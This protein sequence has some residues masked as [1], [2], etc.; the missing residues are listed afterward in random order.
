MSTSLL[1]RVLGLPGYQH[2]SMKD[3]GGIIRFRVRPPESALCCPGCKS[4]SITRRGTYTRLVHAPPIGSR[5]VLFFIDA[6]RVACERCKTV[7]IIKLPGVV[8]KTNHT[9]SLIRMV[10]DLRKMMTI[11]DIAG[12]LGVSTTMIR[13]IDKQY[14]KTHF[15]K[16]RL[17][18]VRQ[19][20]IDEISVRKGH[21]Y[22][23]IVMDLETGAIIFAAEGKGEKSLQSFWKRLRGSGAKVE[24]AATDMS[25]AYYAAVQKNLPN[26]VLVFDR[27]HIAK[28][29]N[30]KLTQLRRELQREAEGLGKDVLKGT[31]WLLLKAPDKLKET[32]NER[33]RLEDALS[34]NQS[35]ATA[36][37]LKEDLRQV[38]EQPGR[39]AASRFLTDWCR[40][41][42]ASGIRVLLTMANT[43]EGYRTGILDWY[44]YPISTGPLEGTNNKIKTM[45]RQAYGYR[46]IEYFKLKLYALHQAK[47]KL[48]G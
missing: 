23:T 15:G 27:F 45:K 40:R 25:S 28:L 11:Q 47:F 12:W 39:V 21:R 30:D 20:A 37:Y 2:Q 33:Q 35:L 19:I 10:V 3:E 41:A 34:L 9:H 5:P 29:M 44:F 14:L 13:N 32:R 17:K 36:Y 22:L 6:P 18:D 42:R 7:R 38:W 8:P 26:A 1:Y 16:P 24:A 31:R 48:V 43:L 46:D 4:T